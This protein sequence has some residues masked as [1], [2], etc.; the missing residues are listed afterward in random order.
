MTG[1][2]GCDK[3]RNV[4]KGVFLLKK[5]CIHEEILYLISILLISF[6]VAMITTTDFG[7]SMIVAP[8]YIFSLK[9]GLTFGQS[10][11]VLQGLMFIVFCICMKKVKLV[12]FSSF[13][14][15]V[16][17]GAVL[18]LWRALIPHFNP[19]VTAPG[20][21]PMPIRLVY[22]T[23]GM[24]LTSLAIALF[25]R[26]YLYPQVYDFFVKGLTEHYNLNRIRFKR[27]FDFSFLTIACAMTLLFFHKFVGVGIGTLIMTAFNGILIGWFT[28]LSERFI[29]VKPLFPK[30]KEKF[31]LR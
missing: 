16:I 7:V 10:E 26:S 17:Y 15:G 28:K 4:C 24:C 23:V 25:F 6:A 3:M 9:T 31:E 21:L 2:T 30:L 18:D 12:Y 22:F 27:I 29:E 8:A 13:L 5:I 20:S 11:Y 14:T 1:G 19:A